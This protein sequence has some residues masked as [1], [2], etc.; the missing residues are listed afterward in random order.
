MSTETL[1]SPYPTNPTPIGWVENSDGSKGAE[2][3]RNT[4]QEKP[5]VLEIGKPGA[6]V[7]IQKG[8]LGMARKGKGVGERFE[9]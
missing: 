7:G 9:S 6:I 2:F 3:D 4:D 5:F 1:T 8:V